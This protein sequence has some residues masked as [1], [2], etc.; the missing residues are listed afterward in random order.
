MCRYLLSLF[1]P[2]GLLFLPPLLFFNLGEQWE[3]HEPHLPRGL[4][5][6]EAKQSKAHW[7]L[8]AFAWTLTQPPHGGRGALLIRTLAHSLRGLSAASVG[9]GP[10]LGHAGAAHSTR[11]EV[12]GPV[13]TKKGTER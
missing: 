9:A 1:L 2:G 7:P 13:D 8:I 4:R 12:W 3:P 11:D 6:Q 5:R 10:H